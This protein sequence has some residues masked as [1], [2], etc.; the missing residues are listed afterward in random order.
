M[1]NWSTTKKWTVYIIAGVIIYFIGYK[2]YQNNTKKTG[3]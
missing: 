2:I 3:Y 1:K